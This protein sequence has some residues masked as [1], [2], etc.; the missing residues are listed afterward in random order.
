MDMIMEMNHLALNLKCLQCSRWF[1]TH[2]VR[3]YKNRAEYGCDHCGAIHEET[4]PPM[5][6]IHLK[7]IIPEYP[8]A[9]VGEMI[10]I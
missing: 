2:Y 10:W 9:K 5:S 1:K 8:S 4:Y 6:G 7:K 3:V